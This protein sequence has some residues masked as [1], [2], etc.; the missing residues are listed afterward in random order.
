[1]HLI[2]GQAQQHPP[3]THQ[4]ISQDHGKKFKAY[5]TLIPNANSNF[6]NQHNLKWLYATGPNFFFCFYPNDLEL[7]G[8]PAGA[9]VAPYVFDKG[10]AGRYYDVFMWLLRPKLQLNGGNL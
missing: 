7:T 2:S 9:A 6:L 3:P 5:T 10:L 1:M 4:S 8:S